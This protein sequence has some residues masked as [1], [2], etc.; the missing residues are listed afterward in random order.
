MKKIALA[1]AMLLLSAAA[2]AA[3]V[4]S[5][6]PFVLQNGQTA[7]ANQVMADFNL[8]R[9][10]ATNN[11]A[12]SGVNSDI[13]ALLGM[14]TP[15][16]PAGG[17]T[18]V[19]SG[20]TS[21]GAANAQVI[22]TTVP[23]SFTLTAGYSVIFT[24]GLTNTAPAT[25]SVN[26]SGAVNIFKGTPAGII[27]LVA[28]DIVG[29]NIYIATFDGT[30]FQLV[31]AAA[32][33]PSGAVFY[34]AAT[35]IPSGYI[36]GDGSSQL[37]ASF[38]T[39][40]AAIGTTYGS[41]DGSHFNLPDCR[42]RMIAGLDSGN[43][44]GRMTASTAQGV[45]AATIGN[46]GGEQAHTLAQAEIPNYQLPVTDP[47]HTHAFFIGN[48]GAGS[49]AVTGAA[50]ASDTVNNTPPTGLAHTGITVASGGSGNPLNEIPP[51]IVMQCML[52]T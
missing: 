18:T 45:S 9:N 36:A 33:V 4:C 24:A 50:N 43:S 31:G 34:T 13:T 17:G 19:F 21:T 47:G 2:A 35:T 5:S 40:F 49:S 3:G 16:A 7:D 25:L 41:A 39:L 44:T 1:L 23:S 48:A 28:N 37:R 32:S 52:K 14:T 38:P 11:L 51:A 22:A 6:Y 27:P 30:E 12:S 46:A 10:C 29:G 42:A 26:G 15:L 8:I 20:G